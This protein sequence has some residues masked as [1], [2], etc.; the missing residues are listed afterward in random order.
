MKVN[1]L[2]LKNQINDAR[3]EVSKLEG[4]KEYLMNSLRDQFGCTTIAEAEAKSKK[5]EKSIS[6]ISDQIE[7]ATAELEEK[8]ELATEEE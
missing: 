4:R 3:G 7:T 5:L 1:L 6:K 8:Y 2:D